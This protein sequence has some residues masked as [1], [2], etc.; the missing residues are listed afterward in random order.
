MLEAMDYGL[1]IICSDILGTRQVELPEQDYV[2][3]K[4]VD[5]LTAAISNLLENPVAAPIQYDLEKYDW[6]TI[7]TDTRQQ[8]FGI[9]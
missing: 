8:L 1:P 4:D 2:P 7:A 5:A 9:N 3:V 6:K